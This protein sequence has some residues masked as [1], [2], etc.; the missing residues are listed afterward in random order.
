[1]FVGDWSSTNI[2]NLT[3][4]LR[5]FNCV[6]GLKVNLDKSSLYGIGVE[7]SAVDAVADIIGCKAETIPAT[8]LGL[9][10]GRN[11]SSCLNWKPIIEKLEKKLSNWKART[12]SVG[13]RHTLVN[14]VL[15]NLGNFWF[16][17]F[18]APKGVIK[19]MEAIRR[20]FVWGQGCPPR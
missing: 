3:R 12:M 1:M 14:N 5:C 18:V 19:R 10:V 6:S 13:G 2:L 4:L 20:D 7:A 17:L 16:S 15:G 11:M 8:F 9:P